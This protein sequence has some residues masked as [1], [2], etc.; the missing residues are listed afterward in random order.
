MFFLRKFTLSRFKF[1][2][3]NTSKLSSIRLPNTSFDLMNADPIKV[4]DAGFL[5]PLR[6]TSII[7]DVFLLPFIELSNI[8]LLAYMRK[9]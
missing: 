7:I 1:N 2:L 3:S 6:R 9:R 5:E 4:Q 8:A